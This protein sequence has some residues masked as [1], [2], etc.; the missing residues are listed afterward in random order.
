MTTN[1]QRAHEVLYKSIT[2]NYGGRGCVDGVI[3]ALADAGL[4][5]PNLPNNDEELAGG[6]R[7]WRTPE[8][9]IIW[10]APAGRVMIQ[11]VEPGNWTPAE[12][13]DV[14]GRILAAADLAEGEA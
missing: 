1:Q 13:R 4:I 8:G 2:C 3:E 11:R 6:S 10:S 14:A 5:A 7:G 9:G 12:A